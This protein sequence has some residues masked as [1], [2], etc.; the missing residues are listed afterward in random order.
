MIARGFRELLMRQHPEASQRLQQ[1]LDR[2]FSLRQHVHAT[3]RNYSDPLRVTQHTL[4][5]I[6][7]RVRDEV[8]KALSAE[9]VTS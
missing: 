2:A 7:M 3:P 8:R 6:A 5:L 1:E 9:G 4:T